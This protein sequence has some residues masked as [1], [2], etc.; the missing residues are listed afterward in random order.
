[1]SAHARLSPSSAH[2][3]MRCTGSVA[4]EA[5]L[6]EDRSSKHAAEGTVAH[7]VAALCLTTSN[8]AAAYLGRVFEADG[9]A[10]TV[11][12]DMAGHV[13]TYLDNIRQYADGNTMM[14]EQKVDFS[15]Y[16]GVKDQF[17]TSDVVILTGDG[18]EIQVHDL[19]FGRGV[20]VDAT[21]NEQLMLYALGALYE[22]GMSGDFQRVRMV[23][24]QPRLNH[25]SEWDCT[26]QDLLA[27]AERARAQAKL[28]TAVVDTHGPFLNPGEKQ[29]RW[30]RAKATCPA[31]RNDVATTVF[32]EAPITADE[33]EVL[34]ET[35]II[36]A[37]TGGVET[38]ISEWLSAALNKVDLIEGWCKAVRA[39]V[40][41]RLLCGQVIPGW[42]L[43][44]GRKGSRAWSDP[45]EAE[46]V[47]KAMRV[48]HEEMYD[49]SVISPTTAEKLH[50][51]GTIGPRQ[52]PKVEALITQ[53][54]GKPSVAPES[55]KRPALV[56]EVKADDFDVVE[57]PVGDLC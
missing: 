33:F 14:V 6:G 42:K 45:A 54:P 53:S 30:C 11:D 41:S 36:P 20:Q 25:L 1:M 12:E 22:F 37:T 28:A 9:F 3:W 24:H 31:L 35:S 10:F 21:E 51:A 47:L 39:E 18:E 19:K 57:E 23:I 4:L 5:K 29:C 38:D 32:G 16:I 48:K 46:Q 8:A 43:V 26:V 13:Q 44:Q 52:W 55:D 2:R 17:G 27:F 49:Y 50:K 40:E 56:I 15:D 7:E 34:T